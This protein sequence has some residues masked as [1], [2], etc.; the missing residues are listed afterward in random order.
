MNSKL[1]G[2]SAI[3][4]LILTGCVTSNTTETKKIINP[5]SHDISFSEVEVPTKDSEKRSIMASS[6]I[7]VDGNKHQI[8]FNTILRSG[9]K[10]GDGV[11]GQIFDSKGNPILEKDGSPKISNR[12][13]FSSLLPVGDKLFMVSHFESLPAAMY[14]TELEQTTNGQLKAIS[15]K[16]IDMS[17]VNGLW[18]PCAGSV[19]P[20]NSHLGSEEYEP[21]AR[22]VKEDGSIDDYY[23]PMAD[24][25][26]GDLKAL[27]PYDYG[28]TPEVT[29]L[30]EKGDVEVEKH[31]A[32]GRFAHELSSVMPDE[33]TVFLSDN[34]TNVAL[35][36]FVADIK[37]DLS[38]GT[39][40]AAKWEQKSNK[41]AGSADLTWVNLGHSTDARIKK[42]LD[43]KITFDDIFETASIDEKCPTGFTSINTT[44]KQ[45]CLK[46]KPGMEEVASRMESRR[47]AAIKGA[48][49]EFRKMEGITFNKEANTLYIGM[50]AIAKG[51]EDFAKKGKDSKEYD[52]GGNND[53]K[54]PYNQCGAVYSLNMNNHTTLDK[55]GKI[56]K[57]SYIPNKMQSLVEGWADSS[58]TGNKCSVNSLANPDN[59]TYISNTNTLII[60]ED[61][62]SG[63]QNDNVWSYNTDQD[64]LTRILTT[65]YGSETTSPYYYNN[66][67]GYGYLMT[68][69]QHPYGE[70]D[71]LT[72]EEDMPGTA[73][74]I[75]ETRAYTGYVGPLPVISK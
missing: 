2:P 38:A 23:A 32:M 56:I 46:I 40:Y 59:V 14:L 50:S 5:Q 31:Y 10:I 51:M 69:V 36:M 42:S 27:N 17:K 61:T 52:G 37:R 8:G 53:I 57:S 16:N 58:V 49:T 25:F 39:L 64:K 15:T 29:V 62:S 55:N 72:S 74:N 11:Y 28:W 20:W 34:G 6:S 54:L 63:H 4:A 1:I 75:G 68:V 47:Y 33:K 18:V 9:D 35:F 22:N 26:G 41:G 71:A 24:Y 30:N 73:K 48:T 60:G 19:T 45:E 3:T 65:P 7:S 66:I 44:M 70:A 13:D 21:N 12:N 67:N 43:K